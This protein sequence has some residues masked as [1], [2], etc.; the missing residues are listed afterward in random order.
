MTDVVHKL[1]QLLDW[2]IHVG[3]R[4]PKPYLPT[5]RE[6]VEALRWD[7]N[8]DMMSPTAALLVFGLLIL[9]LGLYRLYT[10]NRDR[11]N[12]PQPML[13]F[14]QAAREYSV[15]LKTQWLLVRIAKQQGLPNPMTLLICDATMMHHVQAYLESLPSHQRPAVEKQI[16]KIREEL[17]GVG[18]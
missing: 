6:V 13:L 4:D 9:V 2:A 15:D 12:Q 3:P 10:W 1:L 17:F 7:G 18:L 16:A 5:Q 11:H 8:N 14:H